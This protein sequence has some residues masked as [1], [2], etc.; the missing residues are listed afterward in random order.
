LVVYNAVAWKERNPLFGSLYIWVTLA[1]KSEI[2]AKYPSF[3][4]LLETVEINAGIQIVS[5][6]V[7]WSLLSA[8]VIYDLDAPT[9]WENGIFYGM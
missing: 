6:V 1:I 2:V 4:S 8:E 7:L 9:G 3:S 5:M